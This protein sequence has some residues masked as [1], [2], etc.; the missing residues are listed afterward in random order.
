V[1]GKQLAAAAPEVRLCGYALAWPSRRVRTSWTR[2][3]LAD[4]ASRRS[5]ASRPRH[6]RFHVFQ[7]PGK[8]RGQ[9]PP[10]AVAE[11]EHLV[12]DAHAEAAL[13]KIDARFDREDR[14]GGDRQVVLAGV[15]DVE[16]DEVAEAVNELVQISAPPQRFLRRFLQV[17]HR[18]ARPAGSE[19]VLLR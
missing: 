13:G 5:S 1:E 2:Y 10:L 19:N 4:R 16:A 8:I 18:R 17:A 3:A 6:P 15:V 12:L 9:Q 11:E 14:A 7:L